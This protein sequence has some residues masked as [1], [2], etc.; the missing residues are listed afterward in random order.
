MSSLQSVLDACLTRPESLR[1]LCVTLEGMAARP[2]L[3]LAVFCGDVLMQGFSDARALGEALVGM[4]ARC[5][6]ARRTGLE[7]VQCSLPVLSV[8]LQAS[9][10]GTSSRHLTE[11]LLFLGSAGIA[12]DAD[13]MEYFRIEAAPEVGDPFSSH[14]HKKLMPHSKKQRR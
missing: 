10:K 5:E 4:E 1:T 7:V 13:S 3:D 12:P 6:A 2:D 8:L 11:A 9:R 14:Y